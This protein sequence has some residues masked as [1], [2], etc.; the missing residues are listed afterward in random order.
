MSE[1]LNGP[2]LCGGVEYEVRDPQALAYSPLYRADP[3][4]NQVNLQLGSSGANWDVHLFLNNAFGSQPELQR[5]S[6]GFGSNLGYVY[7]LR[8]R[9][10]G[11]ASHLSF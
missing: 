4:I 3:A 7:T 1:T 5:D 11:L 9:T 10:F 6:D 2:C 8:P